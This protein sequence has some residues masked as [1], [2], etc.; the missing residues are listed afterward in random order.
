MGL[1]RAVLFSVSDKRGVAE[2][3]RSI[4]D[5]GYEIW[6]SVGTCAVLRSQG[7]ESRSLDEL[8]GFTDLLNGRVKTLH[9]YV[10]AGILARRDNEAD[11]QSLERLGVPLFDIVVANLYPFVDA[12]TSRKP[13]SEVIENIDIGGVSLIRAAAKNSRWVCVIVRPFRYM[14]VL[15]ELR[16]RGDVSPEL[17]QELAI[18]AFYHTSAYDSYIASWFSSQADDAFTWEMTIGGELVSSLRYGENPHQKAALYR[19]KG[20]SAGIANLRQLQGKELSFNNI[21]DLDA[22]YSLVNEFSE[23]SVAIIKHTNPC[24]LAIADDVHGAYLKAYECDPVSAY[25]GIL[26]ANREVDAITAKAMTSH[27][28]EAVVAPS[29]TQEALEVFIARPLVRVVQASPAL[30]KYSVKPVSGGFLVQTVDAQDFDVAEAKV[31]TS[32]EP[33]PEQWRQLL[34]AWKAVKHV[35]SNAIV[36]A[37]D[38]MLVGVGAGQMSRV[39]SVELA[40]KKAGDRA[41]GSVLASDAFFPMTDG[42]E[43]AIKAGVSAIIQPGGSKR[44]PEIIA[45]VE[46]AGIPMVLTGFRHF[47]H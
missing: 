24:G 1:R 47:L 19:F 28:M 39:E 12:V 2:F 43:L 38:N 41:K 44:D 27:F 20:S 32:T 36:L 37:K 30:P 42:V 18:E 31:V 22:A 33:S 13:D 7:V 14:Q 4:A 46:A 23:P 35:K 16:E 11:L 15:E 3:A 25:G 29:Y 21:M 8:T 5:M 6:A 9:P 26:A 10:Y 40:I 17:R 34:F 45:T